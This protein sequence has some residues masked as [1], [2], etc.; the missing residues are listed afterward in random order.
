YSV[1]EIEQSLARIE[2]LRSPNLENSTLE[3]N[4]HL[5]NSENTPTFSV[6]KN[7]QNSTK[8]HSVK[9]IPQEAFDLKENTQIKNLFT[10]KIIK[11]HG[12]TYDEI[13]KT[14]KFHNGVDFKLSENAQIT[15]VSDGIVEDVLNQKS[16]GLTV[17]IKNGDYNIYYSSLKTAAFKKGDL[18]KKGTVIGTAGFSENLEDPHLHFAIQSISTNKYIDLKEFYQ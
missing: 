12:W 15:S 11:E 6:V 17:K 5:N 18:I 13:L 8:D 1:D 10:N 9:T 14:W 2:S 16:L 7:E 3:T 4:N